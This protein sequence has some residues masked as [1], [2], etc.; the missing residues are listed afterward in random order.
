[1]VFCP[2]IVCSARALSNGCKSRVSPNSGNYIVK[3]KGVH[4][5]VKSEGR[6]GWYQALAEI[7]DIYPRMTSIHDSSLFDDSFAM[8]CVG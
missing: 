7:A 4:H 3:S 6:T 1:M 2:L 5:K 8:D